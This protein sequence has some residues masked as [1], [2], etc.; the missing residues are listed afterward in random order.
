MG[1]VVGANQF[2]SGVHTEIER[3]ERATFERRFGWGLEV[4][5]AGGTDNWFHLGIPFVQ[6]D[7]LDAGGQADRLFL[8]LEL[9][10]NARLAE[11]HLR[12]GRSL[13]FQTSP[14]LVG[15]FVNLDIPVAAGFNRNAFTIC[16]RIEFLTGT[17]T[18]HVTFLAAGL[19]IVL[20]DDDL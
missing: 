11:L 15:T 8:Q 5:Q 3:P 1:R 20:L 2:V 16:M 19:H 7:R 13:P 18:G 14:G 12:A 9:N 6:S 10:E 17:P 4:E